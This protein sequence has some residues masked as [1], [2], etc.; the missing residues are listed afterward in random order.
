MINKLSPG[1]N[2]SLKQT[3]IN[4]TPLF[5][6]TVSTLL[7]M[8]LGCDPFPGS[9]GSSQLPHQMFSHCWLFASKL[10]P[11]CSPAGKHHLPP[12]ETQHGNSLISHLIAFPP[13]HGYLPT[14]SDGMT[15]VSDNTRGC[16]RA[17][18]IICV[19]TC[20]HQHTQGSPDT[21]GSFH[22]STTTR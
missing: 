19:Y 11:W 3:A 6:P 16:S 20:H 18:P 5:P 4:T 2:I 7:A 1:A 22:G 10:H 14:P 21:S 9:T 15:T 13:A 17:K 8:A 12:S